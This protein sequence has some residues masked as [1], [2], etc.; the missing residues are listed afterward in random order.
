MT[1]GCHLGIEQLPQ[2]LLARSAATSA[3][4]LFVTSTSCICFTK[5]GGFT[6]DAP[7]KPP[8]SSNFAL[9]LFEGRRERRVGRRRHDVAIRVDAREDALRVREFQVDTDSS[10]YMLGRRAPLAVLVFPPRILEQSVSVLSLYGTC[11][12]FVGPSLSA[13]PR[14][15]R[16]SDFY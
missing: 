9:R 14:A 2:L 5:L 3:W 10:A 12:R 11:G 6:G 1:L 8:W 7:S 15:P 13:T 16:C 4:R